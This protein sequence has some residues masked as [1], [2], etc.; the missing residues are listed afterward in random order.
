MNEYGQTPE[1]RQTIV[2][3]VYVALNNEKLYSP[4]TRRKKWNNITNV[5]RKLIQIL[6]IFTHINGHCRNARQLSGLNNVDY[7]KN[8]SRKHERFCQIW[9]FEYRLSMLTL[10]NRQVNSL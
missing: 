4:Y 5:Y 2:F 7:K 3:V 9:R 10:V 1:Y 6:I 8:I